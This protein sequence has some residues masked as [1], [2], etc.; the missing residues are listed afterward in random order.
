MTKFLK[1]GEKLTK[2]NFVEVFT[3]F[4]ADVSA[5]VKTEGKSEYQV[6][7][8]KIAKA[9]ETDKYN[10]SLLKI[11]SNLSK[12]KKQEVFSK[13]SEAE[14]STSE[15]RV[16]NSLKTDLEFN[17]DVPSQKYMDEVKRRV[18]EAKNANERVEALRPF[19]SADEMNYIENDPS[20]DRIDVVLGNIGPD[21]MKLKYLGAIGRA[22]NCDKA[23]EF[24]APFMSEE[25]LNDK[26]YKEYDLN[27]RKLD[28]VKN[29]LFSIAS[30]SL[31]D[32]QI[33][34]IANEVENHKDISE[35]EW[36]D[37]GTHK[38]ADD[39]RSIIEKINAD[40]KMSPEEKAQTVA[41]M[42]KIDK[43]TIVTD[44]RH[45]NKM[46]DNRKN[47]EEAAARDGTKLGEAFLAEK[48]IDPE[49]M[50][51]SVVNEEKRED[52]NKLKSMDIKLSDQ[53]KQNIKDI[54][55][56]LDE[57][58]YSPDGILQE[59]GFKAYALGAYE[60]TMVDYQKAIK[61]QNVPDSIKYAKELDQHNKQLHELV[62]VVNEKFP[63]KEGEVYPGNLDVLRNSNMPED[64][65]K[66]VK[67]VSKL[68]ALYSA[69]GFIKTAG[70]SVDEFLDHPVESI[71]NYYKE[72]AY[73][74]NAPK[75]LIEGKSGGD[76]AYNLTVSNPSVNS[77]FL[78]YGMPRIVE[79]LATFETDPEALANN[80]ATASSFNTTVVMPY[81]E[82]LSSRN[83]I[84]QANKEIIDRFLIVKEVQN[85]NRLTA[86]SY[87]DP[88]TGEKIEA[89]G[90]DEAEYL[91]KNSESPSDFC[92]RLKDNVLDFMSQNDTKGDDEV[93]MSNTEF[94][95]AAQRAAAKYL[96]VSVLNKPAPYTEEDK[97]AVK[98]L[99]SF[100][101]NGK[102]NVDKWIDDEYLNP[103][104]EKPFL[105]EKA[106]RL[107]KSFVCNNAYANTVN[108]FAHQYEQRKNIVGDVTPYAGGERGKAT[109]E[110]KK[111]YLTDCFRK[112]EVPEMF[113]NSRM[114]QLNKGEVNA[115][116][117]PFFAADDLGDVEDYITA[118][119]GEDAMNELSD[120]EKNYLYDRYVERAKEDKRMFLTKQYMSEHSLV[121]KGQFFTTQEMEN[122]YQTANIE[123][124]QAEA[125]RI[126]E[127]QE[128][129]RR[130]N[131][132]EEKLPHDERIKF[133]REG[134]TI[135]SQNF[136][137]MTKRFL[138]YTLR[139]HVEDKNLTEVQNARKNEIVVGDN[140]HAA[141]FLKAVKD[142][143][144][145]ES[146]EQLL[147]SIPFEKRKNPHGK[148]SK[149]FSM[150]TNE[151]YYAKKEAMEAMPNGPQKEAA[152][153]ELER[154][155]EVRHRLDHE[156][157]SP[158][159]SKELARPYVSPEKLASI[160]TN[161]SSVVGNAFVREN[162]DYFSKELSRQLSTQ[163][164]RE[165]ADEVA[166]HKYPW[167]RTPEE[168]GKKVYTEKTE[169]A[170]SQIDAMETLN[171]EPLS[172]ERKAEIKNTLDAANDFLR[173]VQ[174]EDPNNYMS[175]STLY[176]NSCLHDGLKNTEGQMKKE[177]LDPN[178]VDEI[179]DPVTKDKLLIV[180]EDKKEEMEKWNNA[181][182]KFSPETKKAIKHIFAKMHEYGYDKAGM[183]GEQ[184]MSKEYGLSKLADTIRDYKEAMAGGDATKIAEAAEK[185]VTEKQHVDE[186]LGYI[187]ENFPVDKDGNFAIAGNIEVV[188]NNLFPPYLRY[189]D[190]AVTHLSSMYIMM[191]FAAANGIEPDEF[192][193]HPSKYMRDV[194][195]GT[196]SKN[197]SD[198]INGKS[199]AEALFEVCKYPTD[200]PGV[201]YGV[202]R[203][204][205]A[206]HFLDKDPEV[207]AHNHALGAFLETTVMNN[208]QRE[209]GSRSVA[210]HESS[211]LERLLYVD[212]P[213]RDASL[214]G[215]RVY[216]AK[217]L[218]Y[219]DAKTFDDIGYLQNNGKSV[220]EMKA[221]LDKNIL[222]YLRL[223]AN[224]R[225]AYGNS[226]EGIS[227]EKFLEITQKA[228]GQILTAK[229]TDRDD[230]AY[231]EL[232]KLM[233]N[234]NDYVNK[235]IAA[236]KA[237][238]PAIADT[239]KNV[240]FDS[241]GNN[242]AETEYQQNRSKIENMR[243]NAKDDAFVDRKPDRDFNALMKASQAEVATIDSRID[244]RLQEIVNSSAAGNINRD[245]QLQVL[246]K[247]KED[248]LAEIEQ[249]KAD[250]LKQLDRDVES[251]RIPASYKEARAQQVRENKFDELPVPFEGP[252]LMSKAEYLSTLQGNEH[253]NL[254]DYDDADKEALY[255]AYK[256]RELA[257]VQKEAEDFALNKIH[258]EA[259]AADEAAV[260]QAN[261]KS[262]P[263]VAEPNVA[264]EKDAKEQG[265]DYTGKWF[266]QGQN[267]TKADLINK[268]NANETR[269]T[270]PIEGDNW[271]ENRK[272]Y[273]ERANEKDRM[274]IVFKEGWAKISPDGKKAVY[275]SL[276]AD[277]KKQLEKETKSAYIR[278]LNADGKSVESKA[279]ATTINNNDNLTL[280]EVAQMADQFLTAEEKADPSLQPQNHVTS[281]DIVGK[282]PNCWTP[283]VNALSEEDLKD[284]TLKA[285][286]HLAQME[287]SLDE[288]KQ[289][290]YGKEIGE[291]KKIVEDLKFYNGNEMTEERKEQ[292][293]NTLDR[294]NDMTSSLEKEYKKK[295]GD[296]RI[297]RE[298]RDYGMN[299]TR[300]NVGMEQLKGEGF[301][302]GDG[303]RGSLRFNGVERVKVNYAGGQSENFEVVKP[304]AYEEYDKMKER[305]FQ[306]RPETK[307]SIKQIF[308]K[309]DEYGYDQAYFQAEEGTKVYGLHKYAKARD[310]FTAKVESNDPIDKLKSV[311][312]AEKMTQEYD[313]AKELI[314][315]SRKL[316][317]IDE[318]GYYPGNLDVERNEDL[319]PEFRQDLGGVSAFNGLYVL[320]RTLKESNA[321]VDKFLEDP[322]SFIHNQVKDEI[323]KLDPNNS[324][325]GKSGADAIFDLGKHSK[326]ISPLGD[327][328]FSRSIETI[329]K[330]ETD[331]EMMKNNI[332][333]EHA[334]SMTDAFALNAT[335]QRNGLISAGEHNL[336]RFL[337]VKEPQQDA[338]LLGIPLYDYDTMSLIPV[339]PFDDVEYLMNSKEDPKEFADRIAN[340]GVKLLAMRL[341]DEAGAGVLYDSIEN[342][343]VTL[344]MK[345]AAIKYIATHPDLDKKSEA[346]RTLN[347][348][349]NDAPTFVKNKLTEA[350]NAGKYDVDL[351]EVDFDNINKHTPKKSFD[352]FRKSDAMKNFGEDVRTT[353]KEQNR[354]LKN[355]QSELQRAERN[356][357]RANNDVAKEQARQQ[358]E[359]ARK[360]LNDAVTERKNQLMQDFRAGRITEEYL[361][362]RNAQLDERKFNDKVPKMFEA[363]ELMSKNDYLRKKYPDDF[364][365]FSKEEKN[366]LYQRYV[367]NAKRSKD[368]FIA[369]KYLEE[370]K[371]KIPDAKTKAE[372]EAAE[373]ERLNALE[374]IEQRKRQG[375]EVKQ[376]AQ[377]KN[378]EVGKDQP[379][380]EN[381][382]NDLEERINENGRI[383]IDID[384]EDAPEQK[385]NEKVENKVNEKENEKVVD[386]GER[387][388]IDLDD[389]NVELNND[390]LNFGGEQPEL[391]KD[392]LKK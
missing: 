344:M 178:I 80:Q 319:P 214:L 331:P 392:S 133:V 367:D 232:H 175:V 154:F 337:I 85:D 77:T 378:N 318:G 70:I 220:A 328:A 254:D 211:H 348:I 194:F 160:D 196:L 291:T 225:N 385:A 24:A 311:E 307:Q 278:L 209:I 16:K 357:A 335:A 324:I 365:G 18:G 10:T 184:G 306:L 188:R 78:G 312:A 48:G 156:N 104:G 342:E 358:V 354:T 281:K 383:D 15:T 183:V 67:G 381:L 253:Y 341:E 372:K 162:L 49:P 371:V 283:F 212:E 190:A 57:Y 280:A 181:E 345:N 22:E 359:E 170:K 140:S 191:N 31:S 257:P 297:D 192:L 360:R 139:S 74:N 300:K 17:K 81:N 105:E 103:N 292:I 12:E 36:E 379:K 76:A 185:M 84:D 325:K 217:K 20:P 110:E 333:T 282:N 238:S 329:S 338:S 64:L 30:E 169:N 245:A 50:I 370:I 349:V 129:E 26:K 5:P 143:I 47:L 95:K 62:N 274:T 346:Y 273:E 218:G 373:N 309:F 332:A 166:A 351:S 386:D 298:E 137:M 79:G 3:R 171:G 380:V 163:Q 272:E 242:K 215:V 310:E 234:G 294:A 69:Y 213:Q 222:D 167:E 320:Y 219:D 323:K 208:N 182:F 260:N 40:D 71:R 289:E 285:D 230:P 131:E 145:P 174:G 202:S 390:I 258:K 223:N 91:S 118:T 207:R 340:E 201:G 45:I 305:K 362:K 389:E 132:A 266:K 356:F 387:V 391:N 141:A 256:A 308:A 203:A 261:G 270:K 150:A 97:Q 293:N 28:S 233:T 120:S 177:G 321:D 90:F 327:Y 164:M 7:K 382:K 72:E 138:G 128:A 106:E 244:A 369:N 251:G 375:A 368:A 216:N 247:L 46:N 366:E 111:A 221:T 107:H 173:E 55:A 115:K 27:W 93:S 134:E 313:K 255:E 61:S 60:K 206:L 316:F 287:K 82:L 259:I 187:K 193:E 119:Y 364:A 144:D 334:H 210:Y 88:E 56:K 11:F 75:T 59:E 250:Y 198:N 279:L 136:A 180:K 37:I 1:E 179:K 89:K 2:Q 113:Y 142:K 35:M 263:A 376:Q 296:I 226:I 301:D 43:D 303:G 249:K 39:T 205:E 125:E 189:D 374:Q 302:V 347:S 114:A 14:R 100:V 99:L 252:K 51:G 9:L 271:L 243:E 126:A 315:M 148:I 314:D 361:D 227:Q 277:S 343:H 34:N 269:F 130:M 237:K 265:I 159:E 23:R 236:E 262:G 204:F 155:A 195:Q 92:D 41:M 384:E 127:E 336:D 200:I 117:P 295:L 149:R 8:E 68:N 286:N 199:G 197:L 268:L 299:V 352:E 246:A 122:M 146:Y 317:G 102:A 94:V 290:R 267:V 96:M 158:E 66:D 121:Q 172:N 240:T 86:A 52:F 288:V 44:T 153:A 65:R 25:Q 304:E 161:L 186:M 229:Y 239:F 377:V 123:A 322:R 176:Q 6:A 241:R 165:I 33:A 350:V 363:D 151:M 135:N 21:N 32:E 109:I 13:L 42:N 53:T 276:N 355:L 339:K 330:L 157:L 98:D 63:P 152:K 168:M 83:Q 326:S 275:D 124:H 116:M 58:G 108:D 54:F 248:K 73:E 147:R 19:M 87:V 228:A 101:K 38:L 224:T 4:S 112:G 29:D 353:D 388:F 284:I 231:E 264:A 235:L